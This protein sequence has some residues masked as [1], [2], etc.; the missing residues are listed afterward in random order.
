MGFY[1]QSKDNYNSKMIFNY[2][3]IYSLFHKSK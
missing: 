3:K 1:F 2:V